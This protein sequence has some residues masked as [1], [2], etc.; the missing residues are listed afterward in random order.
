MKNIQP[1]GSLDHHIHTTR[2]IETSPHRNTGSCDQEIILPDNTSSGHKPCSF[3]H[4]PVVQDSTFKNHTANEKKNAALL[5]LCRNHKH[6]IKSF[7]N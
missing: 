3:F 4:Q 2:K 6:M 5:S 7:K 1:Y